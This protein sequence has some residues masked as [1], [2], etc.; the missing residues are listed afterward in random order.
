MRWPRTDSEKELL[1]E[2]RELFVELAL[3]LVVVLA[4]FFW[5]FTKHY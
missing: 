5:Y 3:V 2:R 4:L 1:D